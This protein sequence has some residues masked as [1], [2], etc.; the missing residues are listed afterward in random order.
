[1]TTIPLMMLSG[2]LC[3]ELVWRDVAPGLQDVADIRFFDFPGF[4]TLADMA[5]HV[6][7][8]A[9]PRFAVCGHSMGGRVAMEMARQAPQRI[10]GMAL[11]NTGMH[12]AG[13]AEPASR[14]RLVKLAREQGMAALAA[15][16]L[17]PMLDSAKAPDETLLA[18]LSAMVEAQSVESFAGQIAALLGRADMAPPLTAYRGPVLLMSATGDSWSPPEQHAEMRD[19]CHRGTLDIV[20]GAGHFLPLEQPAAVVAALRG[21][22][23]TL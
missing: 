22:L 14:G 4:Q 18:D 10:A 12:P 23:A 7:S 9:P 1:M 8:E 11:L 17:P 21:W 16:W 15:A 2:L 3:D 5:T 13:E 20:E 19:I 6:L